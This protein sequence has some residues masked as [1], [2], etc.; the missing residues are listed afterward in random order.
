MRWEEKSLSEVDQ[1]AL[2][3]F[4]KVLMERVRDHAIFEMD[5]ALSGH[6]VDESSKEIRTALRGYSQEDIEVL[7]WLIP[8]IVDKTIH[9][10][11]W[12][13][14]TDEAIN[15]TVE[16][17]SETS[18]SLREISD[19]LCGETYGEDGWIALYSKERHVDL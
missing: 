11:L 12:T 14:D 18:H 13:L 19:G 17:G 4:G 8:Q 16:T 10:L 7:K 2:D 1:R 15:V 3:Y 9:Y 5:G 6:M